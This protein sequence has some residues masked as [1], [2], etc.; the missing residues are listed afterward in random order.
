M[1][2]RISLIAPLLFLLGAAGIVIAQSGGGDPFVPVRQV[3]APRPQAIQYNRPL[4]QFIWVAPGGRLQLVDA[5]TLDVQHELYTNQTYKAVQFNDTGTLLAVAVDRKVDLWNPASGNLL[6]TFEP[7]GILD[8]ANPIQFAA[9]DGLLLVN[10]VVPAPR[11]LRR[12]ENDTVILPWLWDI[13]NALGQGQ[14]QL[15]NRTTAYAFF[16]YRNGFIIGPNDR[17]IAARPSRLEVLDVSGDETN[18]VLDTIESDRFEQDPVDAW[19]STFNDYLYVLP[20]GRDFVQINTQDGRAR[21]L[22]YDQLVTF[23]NPLAIGQRFATEENSLAQLFLGEGYLANNGYEPLQLMLLDALEP[24]TQTAA[25]N[26]FIISTMDEAT[27]RV[28]IQRV[29]PPILKWTLSND[30]TQLAVYRQNND[31]EVYDIASGALIQTLAPTF[32]DFDGRAI[33]AFDPTGSQLIYDFQRFDIATGD[34]IFEEL[35]YNTGFDAYYFDENSRRLTTFNYLGEGGNT[36]RWWQWD[37]NTGEVVRREQVQLRGELRG[38][39]YTGDRFLT[40]VRVTL[41]GESFTALEI[42]EVGKDDRSQLL[43]D[44]FP[45]KRLQRVIPSPNWT[46]ALA[47]YTDDVTGLTDIAM[48]SF[49]DGMQGYLTGQDLPPGQFGDYYWSDDSTVVIPAG[50]QS[51]A[52]FAVDYG[53]NYDA[54][55]LPACLVDAFPEEYTRWVPV[56]ERRVEGLSV[57]Q[58]NDL[59]R[60]ICEALPAAVQGVDEIITTPT[61]TAAPTRPANFRPTQPVLANVPEC[62]T[63][64]FAEEADQYAEVWREISA[65]VTGDDLLELETIV[66]EGLTATSGGGGGASDFADGAMLITID[67]SN[68]TFTQQVPRPAQSPEV[69]YSLAIVRTEYERFN[70]FNRTLNEPIISLDG[71]L[72]AQRDGPYVEIIRLNKPYDAMAAEATA[73]VSVILSQTPNPVSV[74]LR[75]T[76][77]PTSAFIGQPRP[78]VTPTIT[79][80]S[81]PLTG[82]IIPLE[83]LNVVQDF[84]DV[85]AALFTLDNPP[86]EYNPPGRLYTTVRNDSGIYSFD[87]STGSSVRDP[88]IPQCHSGG[89]NN[90]YDRNWIL[91]GGDRPIIT[92]AD[93]SVVRELVDGVRQELPITAINWVAGTNVVRFEY[94]F[95]SVDGF[96]PEFFTREYDPIQDFFTEP[97]IAATPTPL[98]RINELNSTQILAVQ[99]LEQRYSLASTSFNT[100]RGTGFKFYIMDA[101]TGAVAYFARRDALSQDN[102]IDYRWDGRGRYLFYRFFDARET[103][104]VF[105]ASSARHYIY[106]ERLPSGLRSRDGRYLVEWGQPDSEEIRER[107][108]AGLP[109][110]QLRVWD[111]Q[112]GLLRRYCIPQTNDANINAPLDWSPDSRYLTF[113]YNLPASYFDDAATP[114]PGTTPTPFYGVPNS[115]PAFQAQIPRTF[116]LDTETGQVTL[117]SDEINDVLLW[118]QQGG[119]S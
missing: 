27:A 7:E 20:R 15:P 70:D 67:S 16:E 60:D 32:P 43:I 102:G 105:D 94:A 115:E 19:R 5:A 44:N 79:P 17:V 51:P 33:L 37:V 64:R 81:P 114:I 28:N 34:V 77:T 80:T 89:C 53:L 30:R 9:D 101:Q 73:T 117:I 82:E 113:S 29:T 76:I 11:E 14:S 35:N 84:C 106:G 41:S 39:W 23:G 95:Y 18:V 71:R 83:Q 40:Q 108:E 55:G 75:P 110:P 59:T 88:A 38:T 21:R 100:G 58:L 85:A 118:V 104:Y 26:Q 31:I 46:H 69:P 49:D 72:I 50:G 57:D 4:D 78:T 87:L 112:T 10:S 54:T 36:I 47:V 66:C 25:T 109:I 12:S 56:W 97:I 111:T 61:A 2:R 22:N 65:G 3:G 13:P 45:D 24:L 68:R 93:G 6:E 91:Y 74:S 116:V 98:P 8:I 86:P 103:W 119:E 52:Q 90:S 63:L 42:V 1:R 62:I 107:R 48:Y 96:R 99:P 92:R